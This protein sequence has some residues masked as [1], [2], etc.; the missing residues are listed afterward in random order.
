MIV[1]LA[2]A[3]WL[4]AQ[5]AEPAAQGPA[6]PAAAPSPPTAKAEKDKDPMVCRSSAPVGSRLPGKRV[7]L[8]KSVMD[9]QRRADREATEAMQRSGGPPG[10]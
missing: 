8:P 9:E 3:G 5:A 7:C 10:N 4:L 6:A 1:V 2:A